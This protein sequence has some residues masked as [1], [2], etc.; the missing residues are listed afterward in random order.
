[1]GTGLCAVGIETRQDAN[2]RRSFREVT[3]SFR[4]FAPVDG[5]LLRRGSSEPVRNSLS[6]VNHL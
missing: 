1:M 5:S 6:V 3:S 2:G 4:N